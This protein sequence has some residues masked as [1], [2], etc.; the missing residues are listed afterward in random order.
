[1][2]MMCLAKNTK[3]IMHFRHPS[4]PSVSALLENCR[5]GVLSLNACSEFYWQM[6]L[7]AAVIKCHIMFQIHQGL[8][9][10][11]YGAQMLFLLPVYH[12]VRFFFYFL[13]FYT[14]SL[15]YSLAL[16]VSDAS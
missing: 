7:N 5:F 8:F 14:Y 11:Q 12:K 4:Y 3:Q 13:L 16:S 15:Q 10:K 6:H 9:L 2:Y 1:M